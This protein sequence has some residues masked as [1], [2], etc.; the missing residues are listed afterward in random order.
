MTL[1]SFRVGQRNTTIPK[2]GLNEIVVLFTALH[3][4]QHRVAVREAAGDAHV[5]V[6]AAHLIGGFFDALRAAHVVARRNHDWT[7]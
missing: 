4:L 6:Q 2:T 7:G 3:G 1:T 5:Q